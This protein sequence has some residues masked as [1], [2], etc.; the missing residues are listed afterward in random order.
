MHCLQWFVHDSI[1][2]TFL[3]QTFIHSEWVSET[4]FVIMWEENVHR[5]F[6]WTGF[7]LFF[8]F[9]LILMDLNCFERCAQLAFVHTACLESIL[10][11]LQECLASRGQSHGNKKLTWRTM[12]HSSKKHTLAVF[13]FN[14]NSENFINLILD[15]KLKVISIVWTHHDVYSGT[16]IY[17]ITEHL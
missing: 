1:I 14:N 15:L 7:F 6:G 5:K 10:H 16:W 17:N 11:F 9:S 8:F 3:S 13:L 12:T 4:K 2:D